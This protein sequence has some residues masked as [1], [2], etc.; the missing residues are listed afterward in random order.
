MAWL[1]L[2]LETLEILSI[3][4]PLQ[5]RQHAHSQFP[6]GARF[7]MRLRQW[8]SWSMLRPTGLISCISVYCVAHEKQKT[9]EMSQF[10]PNSHILGGSCANAPFNDQGQIWQE[11]VDP[12]RSAFTRQI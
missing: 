4:E 1:G 7:G 8:A 3:T 11:S 6:S 5:N 2:L 10:R 9:T 12:S